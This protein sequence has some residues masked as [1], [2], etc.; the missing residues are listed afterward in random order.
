MERALEVWSLRLISM[1]SQAAGASQFNPELET[2]FICHSQNHWFCIR[3]V[4]GE[5]YNL[6]SLNPVPEQLSQFYL[7]AYLDAS[8]GSGWNIYAV[9]GIFPTECPSSSNDFGKWL[10]PD[11]ARNIKPL[12]NQVQREEVIDTEMEMTDKHNLMVAIAISLRDVEVPG[13]KIEV[14]SQQPY[15]QE[16]MTSAQEENDDDLKVAIALSLIPFEAP[17]T[18]SH[19]A[20]EER[21]SKDAFSKDSTMEERGSS[22]SGESMEE[23]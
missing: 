4:N 18:S 11:E 10:S 12:R 16:G 23:Y 6:N 14:P 1:Y 17:L 3:N 7:S 20:Q 13:T 8:R 5:W 21:N 15:Q 19:P 22:E 9:R 2:A